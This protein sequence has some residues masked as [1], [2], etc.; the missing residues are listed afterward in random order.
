MRHFCGRSNID[1]DGTLSA[2]RF[3]YCDCHIGTKY[4]CRKIVYCY[5]CDEFK[6]ERLGEK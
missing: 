1:M 4:E 2:C 3:A 5:E 6:E